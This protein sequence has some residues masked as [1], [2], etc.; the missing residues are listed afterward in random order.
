MELAWLIEFQRSKKFLA[1]SRKADAS[2]I[3]GA[4]RR[5]RGTG[6]GGTGSRQLKAGKPKASTRTKKTAK[7]LQPRDA[8]RE[9]VRQPAE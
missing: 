9:T 5:S 3:S 7:K 6:D 8:D 2:K 1:A 4:D